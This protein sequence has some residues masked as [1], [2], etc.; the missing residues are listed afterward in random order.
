MNRFYAYPADMKLTIHANKL[1]I[2]A[3][4]HSFRL[5]ASFSK[6][7]DLD[8]IMTLSFCIAPE[9]GPSNV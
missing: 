8:K 3:R 9:S 5:G 2:K 7:K 4:N 1:T 6:G